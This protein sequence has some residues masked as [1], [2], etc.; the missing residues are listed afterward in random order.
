MPE[1]G[2]ETDIPS[3]GVADASERIRSL[4][5][6]PSL[7]TTLSGGLR[8]LAVSCMLLSFERPAHAGSSEDR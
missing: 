6:R 5:C 8:A 1:L 3:V 2:T 4:A 7:D